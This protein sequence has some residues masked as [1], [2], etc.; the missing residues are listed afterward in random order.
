MLE[1]LKRAAWDLARPVHS[2][3]TKA[4]RRRLGRNYFNHPE[5]ELPPPYEAIQLDVE[6]HL[7]QYL[8]VSTDDIS[9][10]VIV[11]AHE[12]DEVER[13][14]R[15]Y[16]RARFLCF[17]PNPNTYQ[18]LVK[19]FNNV[20]YVKLFDLALSNAPGKARFYEPDMPGT[21]SLLEPDAE[22]WAT[23]SKWKNKDVTSFQVNVSTLDQETKT[24]ATLDLL[25]MDVQGA[26]GRVL[27]GA[28]ETLQRTKAI[29]LEV[30]LTQSPYKGALLFEEVATI[31]KS[32][33]FD[34]VGLGLDAWNGTGN[35]FFVKQFGKLVCT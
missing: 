35:A 6:R 30:A 29:F 27:T 33:S 19:K 7:H 11:G 13:L 14:H 17:E 3:A 5:M 31:L 26:E 24:M 12:A 2:P 1:N 4:L 21:G 23:F 22:S 20:P 28:A 34:C 25:W 15:S 9:Q 16:P 18:V 10:V 32:S 8:H